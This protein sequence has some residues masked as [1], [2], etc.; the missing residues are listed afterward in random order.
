MSRARGR[1][2]IGMAGGVLVAALGTLPAPVDA[3]E[4]RDRRARAEVPADAG[5]FAYDGRLTF[6][7]IRFETRD[8][9]SGWSAGMPPWAHDYPVAER[10]FMQVLSEITTVRP[11]TTGSRIVTFDDPEVFRY[12]I[13]YVSEPGHW[14]ISD[15]EVDGMRAYLA[16]GGFIIFDDFA[17]RDWTRFE[18]I[19]RRVLPDVRFIRMAPSHPL[20]SAFFEIESLDM[21]HPYRRAPA[22]FLGIFEDNDPSK[23]ILAIANYNNDIGDYFEYSA[24]GWYPMDESNTAYK[25]GINYWVWALTR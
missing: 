23:R 19:M 5:E 20:F 13:A 15:D 4:F 3:Q 24:T 25:L 17:G 8:P 21:R 2:R 7:R 16:K 9:W 6:A 18:E 12:P 11:R 1:I 10:N 14:Q 22:E